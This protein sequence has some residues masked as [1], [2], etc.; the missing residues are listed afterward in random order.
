MNFHS[1]R[2]SKL[3]RDRTY[4]FALRVFFMYLRGTMVMDKEQVTHFNEHYFNTLLTKWIGKSSYVL[5]ITGDID[6]GGYVH[7]F[8]QVRFVPG[9]Q[10]RGLFK[11]WL[12][13]VEA[14]RKRHG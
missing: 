4:A 3:S 12:K 11:K 2:N 7:Q 13:L 14:W 5:T 1:E 10:R 8:V 6:A 9:K